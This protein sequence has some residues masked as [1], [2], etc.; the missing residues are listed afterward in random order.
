MQIVFL[1]WRI[2]TVEDTEFGCDNQEQRFW[3]HDTLL[4]Y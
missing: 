4:S 1:P 2:S 3:Q